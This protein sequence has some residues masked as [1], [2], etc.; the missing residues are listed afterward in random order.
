MAV[1]CSGLHSEQARS[2]QKGRCKLFMWHVMV[3]GCPMLHLSKAIVSKH[4]CTERECLE[5]SHLTFPLSLL[6][7]LG[8][9][10][11]LL[12]YGDQRSLAPV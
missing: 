2:K 3:G 6:V 8:K 12:G 1:Y 7:L 11:P 10:I 5:H 4:N 9:G